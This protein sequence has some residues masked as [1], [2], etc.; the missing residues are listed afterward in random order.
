MLRTL[1]LLC[2]ALAAVVPPVAAMPCNAGRVFLDADRDGHADPDEPGL[3]DVAVSDG[4]RVVRTDAEGRYAL[5]VESGR[6]VFVV[7]PAGYAVPAGVDGLPR[8]WR[9]LQPEPGPALRYGGIPA[10]PAACHDFALWP[11]TPAPRRRAEALRVLVFGDPQPKTAQ[12]VAHYRGDIVQAVLDDA[13]QDAHP[14]VPAADLGL[15]LGDIVHDDL[16]LYPLVTAATAALGVPWLHAPG[17]HDL[18]FDAAGDEDSL[19]TFRNSFGPDT[20]AWEEREAV[21]VVLDDVIYLPGQRPEYIGGL[22]QAQFAFLEAY[23]PTV[24]KDRL[25]VLAMHVPLFEEPGRDGF[26]DTDRARL[27]ALLRDFPHVLVLSAHRHTQQHVFHDAASGWQGAAPLHEYNVGAACGAFWSGV[28]D[29]RGIPDATMSDGTPN[30]YAVLTVRPGGAYALA[31]RPAQGGALAPTTPAIA[32]HA[33][34]VLRHGA[35]PGFAVYAN[36][37]MGHERT[38]VE[39]RVDDG[40]WQPMRRVLQPDPRVLAENLRDDQAA[41]LRGYDRI[42]EAT[43]SPHLWR[44]PLPT[45]LAPGEHRIEVRAFDDWQGEQRAATSYR[46]DVATP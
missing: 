29:A 15:S 19:R 45:D 42:P 26:R 44:G 11:Q 35:W 32:L 37:F 31:W 21:F 33:P 7:K 30:G 27:F 25:L 41:A 1:L 14:H 2:T 13:A 38:R 3:P 20:F 16:S 39:Y 10:A 5:P 9:H 22:R 6:T 46:L 43:P 40:P 12:D 28:K 4:L 36:V 8:F 24:P 18:D 23:L 34:K 17:N